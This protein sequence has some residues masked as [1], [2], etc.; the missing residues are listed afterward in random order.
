M[1]DRDRRVGMHQQ[2]GHGL[3]HDVA[4]TDDYGVDSLKSD[5]TTA[6][7]F[8]RSSGRAGH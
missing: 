5:V 8:H 4:A 3:S 6:Q 1:A 7:N 2:Q